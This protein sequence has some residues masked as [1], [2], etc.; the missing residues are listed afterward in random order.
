LRITALR[1]EPV[2][3][4][5]SIKCPY[6]SRDIP[7]RWE[8]LHTL[9]LAGDP[10]EGIELR[11]ETGRPYERYDIHWT[12]CFSDECGQVIVRVSKVGF[13]ARNL[14]LIHVDEWLAVP[15]KRAPRP[16]DPFIPEEFSKPYIRASLILEDAPDMSGGLSRRILQ[17]LLEK[18]AG[19][20]EY[21]L[22]ERIDKFIE[23]SAHPSHVKE[24]LHH[25]RDI[26]NFAAHTKA[27]KE[28]GEIVEVGHKEAE[29][30]LD[31]IDGLFEYFIVGPEKN[32]QRR[33][34][35]DQKRGS[36]NPPAKKKP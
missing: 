30:T 36:Q 31:V 23:D 11:D 32:R 3:V 16:I 33:V 17:D 18:F 8:P 7:C 29:W 21:K 13:D 35:W 12:Q 25:L 2:Q 26:G 15:R 28:T 9:N 22:E 4:A 27:N 14:E 20:S 10:K 34:A 6:C 5:N 24:N 1:F 19:R